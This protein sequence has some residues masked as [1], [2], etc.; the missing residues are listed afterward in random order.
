MIDEQG[1]LPDDVEAAEALVRQLTPARWRA[2]QVMAR[3]DEEAGWTG[4]WRSN[5]TSLD[6]GLVY[7]QSADWLVDAGLATI[8]RWG[9]REV[10]CW[11]DL[12]RWVYR[13]RLGQL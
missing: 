7:W 9:G 12:G 11:T 4:A 3:A 1:F 10:V 8:D 2:M 13:R 6:A 5:S